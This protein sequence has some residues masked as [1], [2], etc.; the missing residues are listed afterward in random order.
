MAPSSCTTLWDRPGREGAIEARCGRTASSRTG[1]FY[2]ISNPWMT[3]FLIN[4]MLFLNE[5]ITHLLLLLFFSFVQFLLDVD[6]DRA[7]DAGCSWTRR[8][9]W[10]LWWF[11][12]RSRDA[13]VAHVT[14]QEGKGASPRGAAAAGEII[15]LFLCVVYSVMDYIFST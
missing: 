15:L 8:P 12:R 2:F 5:Y 14:G 1:A 10:Q 9:W 3:W 11:R 4:L 13:N 6:R 7:G